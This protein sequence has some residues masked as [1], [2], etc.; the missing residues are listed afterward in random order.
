MTVMVMVTVM[1]V[2]MISVFYHPGIVLSALSV[3]FNSPVRVMIFPILKMRKQLG[4]MK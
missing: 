3:L 1:M 4:G 2:M